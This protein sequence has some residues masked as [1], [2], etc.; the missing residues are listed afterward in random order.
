MAQGYLL[1]EADR[2][3]IK[4]LLERERTRP[5]GPIG[6]P[7]VREDDY[8][9]PEVYIAL[10]PN[11]GIPAISGEPGTGT[12]VSK[13]ESGTGTGFR[14][15]P[16]SA[17]CKLYRIQDS[18]SEMVPIGI[19]V[20]VY[21]ISDTALVGGRWILVSRDKAGCW[22]AINTAGG[23]GA[24]VDINVGTGSMTTR[25]ITF[26]SAVTC[27]SGTLSVTTDRARVLN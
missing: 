4:A 22:I 8:A 24:D 26:V 12:H 3:A 23:A 14:D 18:D 19:S 15:F 21:N 7:H 6:R 2:D 25:L 13:A 11:A 5:G 1:S 16:G 20:T 17:V 10:T 27:S 9:A